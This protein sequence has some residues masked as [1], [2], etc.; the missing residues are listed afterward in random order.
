[1]GTQLALPAG[2]ARSFISLPDPR[3]RLDHL[4]QA[5]LDARH[6]IRQVLD[7]LAGAFALPAGDVDV[8]M[9]SVD[10]TLQ[11]LLHDVR[12]GYEHEIEDADPL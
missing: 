5:E 1:M 12:R 7:R 4:V 9:R 8:A 2:W 11:D 10:D 3:D 6:E